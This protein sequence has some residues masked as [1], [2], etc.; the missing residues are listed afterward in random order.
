MGNTSCCSLDA[1]WSCF[2]HSVLIQASQDKPAPNAMHTRH[3]SGEQARRVATHCATLV[4]FA[5]SAKHRIGGGWNIRGS[6]GCL[7]KLERWMWSVG[8]MIGDT[9]LPQ[10]LE[11][12]AA[13]HAG[14][15]NRTP[16]HQRYAGSCQ[17]IWQ[18]G[19][20]GLA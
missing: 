1:S 14:V 3:P 2:N 20:A 5:G 18:G 6:Q 16:A 4:G 19:T 17:Q 13:V 12:V 7:D 10:L 9:L 15:C 11:I 8:S